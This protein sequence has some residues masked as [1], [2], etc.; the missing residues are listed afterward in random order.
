ME[1]HVL[2]SS[3]VVAL[4]FIGYAPYIYDIVKGKT[5]PHAFTWFVVALTAFVAY[6]LQ[7]AGG[8]GVGS[9]ALLSVS[10]I[11]VLVFLL[12]L[13]RG[14]RDITF[15]DIVFLIL[16]LV[17]LL[18]WIVAQE[19]ILSVLLIT[20]AEVLSFFPTIRKS[21][22][23]PYSETLSTYQISGFRH[24]LSIFALQQFNILTVLY[25]VAWTLTNVAITVILMVRRQ[26]IKK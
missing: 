8:A 17:A 13:W 14:S 9:W 16:S 10:G 1:Y 26:Q 6:G 11:C 7:V 18:L 24:G 12:S 20:S 15:S 25:P 4:T 3:F 23:D 21:W 22:K 19:P 2:I 5:K